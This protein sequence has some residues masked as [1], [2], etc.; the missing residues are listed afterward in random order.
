MQCLEE[1][2]IIVFDWRNL[3][4]MFMW[5]N[6]VHVWE[7]QVHVLEG[8]KSQKGHALSLEVMPPKSTDGSLSFDL[9]PLTKDD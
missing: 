2:G 3:D 1:L 4:M 7:N 6:Q 9:H 5:E 8:V